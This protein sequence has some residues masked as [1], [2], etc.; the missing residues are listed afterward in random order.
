MGVHIVQNDIRYLQAEVGNSGGFGNVWETGAANGEDGVIVVLCLCTVGLRVQW[1]GGG[2]ERHRVLIGCVCQGSKT[3]LWREEPSVTPTGAHGRIM[4]QRRRGRVWRW[5][6]H[7][8]EGG[9]SE[10]GTGSVR[11]EGQGRWRPRAGGE[12]GGRGIAQVGGRSVAG[13]WAHIVGGVAA[14]RLVSSQ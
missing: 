4:E 8:R 6:G 11:N 5:E 13:D 10:E 12:G 9:V 2:E 14:I 1:D 3:G 7:A